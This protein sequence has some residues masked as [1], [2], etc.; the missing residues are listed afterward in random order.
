MTTWYDIIFV[1]GYCLVNDIGMWRNETGE[2]KSQQREREKGSRDQ[3]NG[4]R[5]REKVCYKE[6]RK[7]CTLCWY[8]HVFV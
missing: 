7:Y 3:E 8:S 1:F 6:N 4:K 2:I 5:K